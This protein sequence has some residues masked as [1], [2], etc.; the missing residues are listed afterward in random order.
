VLLPKERRTETTVEIDLP[1]ALWTD[2]RV[3]LESVE[4]L[5]IR[6]EFIQYG[7][8]EPSA[9]GLPSPP[10][11]AVD[12]DDSED[13]DGTA[14]GGSLRDARRTAALADLHWL[15]REHGREGVWLWDPFL[16]ADDLVRTLFYCPHGGVQL[17]ALTAGKK[18]PDAT[19]AVGGD[20]ATPAI[21]QKK[22]ARELAKQAT[23]Q[24]AAQLEAAKGNA[25]ELDLE[26]RIRNGPAGWAFHDRFIIFPR[27]VGSSL[28]WSLGTSINS[29]GVE[30]H[31]LQKVS[32]GEPIADAFED[33]WG[34]LKDP[35]YLVWTSIQCEGKAQ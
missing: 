7:L 23:L 2:Q 34:Q 15:M 20:N 10:V 26:F 24:Q 12:D 29:F 17:R 5:K 13:D 11:S 21:D 33:L 8:S 25:H 3:F 9:S 14:E 6:K 16:S 32:H 22:R 1:M 28:A 18:P 19:R 31:I 35:R 4:S 30:H 27:S